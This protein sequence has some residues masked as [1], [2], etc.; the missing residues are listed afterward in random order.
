MP[1]PLRVLDRVFVF[2]CPVC[3]KRFENDSELEPLC[4]GPSATRDEHELTLMVLVDV[5]VGR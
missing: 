3:K 2:R 5:R 1:D 4:T